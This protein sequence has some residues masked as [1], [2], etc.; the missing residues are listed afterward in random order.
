MRTDRNLRMSARE[1][2]DRVRRAR[3]A[4]IVAALCA[5]WSLFWVGSASA[6]ERNAACEGF[7]DPLATRQLDGQRGQGFET[8]VILWD[9]LNRRQAAPP[10]PPTSNQGTTDAAT[11]RLGP[12]AAPTV[13]LT[14]AGR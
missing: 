3:A 14:G 12:I 9:E 4:W 8:S 5:A 13:V 6:D 1:V 10:P 11:V 7:C 2:E